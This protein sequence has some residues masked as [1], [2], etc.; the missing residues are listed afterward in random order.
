MGQLTLI[1]AFKKFDAFYEPIQ[2]SALFSYALNE[3]PVITSDTEGD[4]KNPNIILVDKVRT[5]ESLGYRNKSPV[6]RDLLSEALKKVT[7]Q[8]VGLINSDI[9]IPG[10]F[11]V[12]FWET[13]M[14]NG[15]DSFIAVSRKDTELFSEIKTRSSLRKFFAQKT[16]A[17]D[18]VSSSDLFLGP[19]RNFQELAIS[20]PPFIL[21][22]YG[23]DN[24]IHCY[25]ASNFRCFNG[26]E[27][28]NIRHC[29]HDHSH[30]LEQEGHPGKMA[31]SS[32]HNISLLDGALEKFGSPVKLTSWKI[33]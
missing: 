9:V 18:A 19:K 4:L 16:T 25:A 22:R 23:W 24:W 30:I 17:Y 2:R 8:Y 33:A 12:T 6:L 29:M 14:K 28:F 11:Y 21:G 3:I 7:T 20:M 27:V 5:G 13:M 10:G 26:T 15:D 31:A 1:T 32:A